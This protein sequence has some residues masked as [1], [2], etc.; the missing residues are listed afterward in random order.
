MMKNGCKKLRLFIEVLFFI[1]VIG[2]CFYNQWV[3]NI[4]VFLLAPVKI[5][6]DIVDWK[7]TKQKMYL[8]DIVII[9]MVLAYLIAVMVRG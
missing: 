9:A 3:L 2:A 1:I 8:S 7:E 5:Y 6:F 4:A